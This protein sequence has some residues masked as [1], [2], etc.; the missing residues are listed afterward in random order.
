MS[1]WCAGGRRE[2]GG[3]EGGD[4]SVDLTPMLIRFHSSCILRT[5]VVLRISVLYSHRARGLR[6]IKSNVLLSTLTHFCLFWLI[7]F[8]PT[9]VYSEAVQVDEAAIH[10]VRWACAAAA[11]D[12]TRQT[13]ASCPRGD[14]RGD[15]RKDVQVRFEG[16]EGSKGEG[17][18]RRGGGGQFYV[19]TH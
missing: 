2:S 14:D 13:D 8:F 11:D 18:G 12:D 7:V 5:S 15:C 1:D 19:G 17:L 6:K 16:E 9:Q 3:R 4:M 10:A